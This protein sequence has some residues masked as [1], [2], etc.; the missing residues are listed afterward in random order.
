MH[1]TNVAAAVRAQLWAIADALM[2]EGRDFA[3]DAIYATIE[4]ANATDARTCTIV[5]FPLT[6]TISP[7]ISQATN[8]ILCVDERAPVESNPRSTIHV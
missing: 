6:A 2:W 7:H 3:A 1:D 5:P 8:E 4:E